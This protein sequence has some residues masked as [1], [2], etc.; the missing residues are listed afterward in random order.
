MRI[1]KCE[2]RR[3]AKFRISH[4]AFRNSH[5]RLLPPEYSQGDSEAHQSPRD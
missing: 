3:K 2:M 4:F 1:S 5:F